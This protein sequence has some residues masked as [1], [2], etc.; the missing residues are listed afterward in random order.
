MTS[1]IHVA[2]G[3][4]PQDNLAQRACCSVLTLSPESVLAHQTRTP[5]SIGASHSFPFD[6]TVHFAHQRAWVRHLASPFHG[7]DP[8][9]D[10]RAESRCP[11]A[12]GHCAWVIRTLCSRRRCGGCRAH[13]IHHLCFCFLLCCWCFSVLL[14][15]SCSQEQKVPT[16]AP[17]APAGQF[18]TNV[19][20]FFSR[21]R[22]SVNL[23]EGKA[24]VGIAIASMC[25]RRALISTAQ[26][27]KE[28]N[29]TSDRER[30]AVSANRGR[31]G[32]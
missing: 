24:R 3:G 1:P 13:R 32:D 14:S 23:E 28:M 6:Q 11:T 19:F 5:K 8:R 30:S 17:R 18:A 12:S 9:A 2:H 26:Y 4:G 16:R 27:T 29:R 25:C 22:Y 10:Q 15:C 31:H 20:L 21:Y 7:Q